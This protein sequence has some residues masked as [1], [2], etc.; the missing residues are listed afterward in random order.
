MNK[1]IEKISDGII[2]VTYILNDPGAETSN[3]ELSDPG[4]VSSDITGAL[5]DNAPLCFEWDKKTVLRQ[6]EVS[7]TKKTEYRYVPGEGG[8]KKKMTANGEVTYA[9]TFTKAFLREGFSVSLTFETGEDEL[10]LGMGQYEDGIQDHRNRTVYLYESNMRIAI[11]FLVTTGHYGILIDSE[12][13][14]I[15]NS[16]GN[17]INFL[18]EYASGLSYYVFLGKNIQDIINRYHEITGKPSM[19]PRWVF[20]YIQSKERY[21][22]GKELSDISSEF[23]KRD[24]PIDCLVQDWF[25]WEE[26]LWGEKKFDKKRYPDLP[27][28]VNDLHENNVH[29]MVSIWPNMSP[30][31]ENYAE[32]ANEG[33]LLPNSGTYDAF[34]EEAR[35]LY[36]RQTEEEIMASGTDA[37]WCDN[38]EPFSDADWNGEVRRPEDERYRLVRDLSLQ[39]M[40]PERLNSYGLYHA[41]G[42]YE[43][44]K[45]TCQKKRVVNLTRSGYTGIQK[46]GAILWS[47]D[48]TARYDTMRRQITEGIRMGLT[49][50]PYWTLDI[51]GFFSVD[52]KYENRGCNDTSHK[53]LW[54][55]SGDYNDGVNDLGYRELYTRWIEFGTFLPIFRSHGTDTPREPWNFGELGDMF[56]DAI[57]SNIRLRYRLMPYIY[58]LAAMAHFKGEIIM[59]SLLF[60]FPDDE[61]VKGISDEY[62]FGP[63]LLVAPVYE[64]MYYHKDSLEIKDH[65]KIRRVYLPKGFGWYDFFTEEYHEGGKWIEADAP[66]GKIPVFVREGSILPLSGDISYADEGVG[67]VDL[68]HV[69]TGSDADFSLY[70]DDGDGYEFEDGKYSFVDLEYREETGKLSYREPGDTHTDRDFTVRYISG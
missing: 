67:E 26:G 50:M 46:Y 59:R 39:S 42:I 16:E 11:P 29:F 49:G 13:S 62:L 2:R 37:L 10:L 51:G 40:D 60:D 5:S 32:F 21:K 63:S 35:E 69:Y 36:W 22:S 18:I 33:K 28:T 23:R 14:M 44:W 12:S 53:P 34:D 52:D 27:A 47:G 31:T 45:K 24:I 8:L 38:A 43:N 61:E 19:L 64:P 58:S 4:K 57:V 65:A 7:F 48:I 1:K 3:I 9:E 30:E 55:W 56:Y 54:F 20:G 66:I 15:F 17:R 68:I 6:S 70:L 25:S 41:K